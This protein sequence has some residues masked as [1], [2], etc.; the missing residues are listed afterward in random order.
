[1]LTAKAT[2]FKISCTACA[3]IQPSEKISF[4]LEMFASI[5]FQ[6]QYS[7]FTTAM[8]GVEAKTCLGPGS[9]FRPLF[10][11][12]GFSACIKNL[13]A[14][15]F[16]FLGDLSVE[17]RIR[18]PVPGTQL[19]AR[20]DTSVHDPP[21]AVWKYCG[22]VHALIPNNHVCFEQFSIWDKG[23]S[24]RGCQQRTLSGRLCQR[25]DSQRPHV[26]R[27]TPGRYPSAGLKNDYCRNPDGEI[28]IWCYTQDR[29]K[30]WEFCRPCDEELKGSKDSGYRGCQQRTESN[31]RCQQW[32]SQSPHKHSRTPERF[33]DKDLSG[34]ECRN[35][36]G[37][38]TIWC[39]TEDKNKRWEYC[40]PQVTNM[41]QI[42]RFKHS[43]P[44][45]C[46][47]KFK[48]MAGPLIFSAAVAVPLLTGGDFEIVKGS[49]PHRQGAQWQVELFQLP[50]DNVIEAIKKFWDKTAGPA[51]ENAL[52]AAGDGVEAAG[53]WTVGGLNKAGKWA[54][55]G[56]K[57]VGKFG[58]KVGKDFVGG[59]K[60]GGNA[61]KETGEAL[62]SL[63]KPVW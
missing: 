31:R 45:T 20:F 46:F 29:A 57:D 53:E 35:P 40:K 39:Y 13:G 15:Y 1:M 27:R 12:L 30:R 41:Q 61:L 16:P 36:D 33:G 44:K 19:V 48:A 11:T 14:Q 56:A 8:I 50:F 24:Y 2:D 6:D 62:L 26:H 47:D 7:L 4:E 60:D 22:D 52:N 32:N 9:P 54:V 51:M 23:K 3:A 18:G 37:E 5:N 17:G 49:G 63:F 55:G 28:S 59:V 21:D 38:K 25:W 42:S 10:D 43:S 58:E 34:N